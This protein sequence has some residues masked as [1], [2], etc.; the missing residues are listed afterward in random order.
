MSAKEFHLLVVE[1]NAKSHEIITKILSDNGYKSVTFTRDLA[2]SL[3]SLAMEKT[4]FVLADIQVAKDNNYELLYTLSDE[5][6]F[7]SVR[8]LIM[9]QNVGMTTL[10]KALSISGAD[11]INK[12]FTPY[13]L[14]VKIEKLIFG[15]YAKD[16]KIKPRPAVARTAELAQ[17]TLDKANDLLE[18][19]KYDAAV[20]EFAKAVRQRMLF[21]EA[22]RG[23]AEA[24]RGKGDLE[25]YSQFLDKAAETYA[26]LDRHEEAEAAFQ[27]ARKINDKA[28]NPYK[29]KGD[30]LKDNARITE[31]I[32]TYQRASKLSPKDTD[33]AFAL[34]RAYL[35]R[36]DTDKAR[37]TLE[38]IVQ[39]T[40]VPPEAKGLFVHIAEKQP[41]AKRPK[42]EF[43]EIMQEAY[44]GEEKRRAKRIPLAEY[45]ARLPKRQEFFP[46]V[47]I[48]GT[49]IS[50]KREGEEFEMG[51]E[52]AFDLMLLGEP[53]AKKVMA[54]VVRETGFL[55]GCEFLGMSGKQRRQLRAIIAP[56]E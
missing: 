29:V 3:E 6:Q 37:E 12:P 27:T 9:G 10:D 39:K 55:V 14:M 7:R 52:V 11:Y 2:A 44:N 43:L 21:P 1:P 8:V 23:I 35:Q 48:S 41:S 33:V 40:G 20:A 34:S 32:E 4:D 24:F 31:V 22:Y 26:W 51:H 56:R 36:G 45:A 47:D 16:S 28:P 46:V 49:G 18:L 25:R 17:K 38:P 42:R 50:F 30:H 19:R 53:K 54:K 13:L 15:P 5:P